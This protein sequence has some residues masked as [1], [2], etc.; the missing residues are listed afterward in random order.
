MGELLDIRKWLTK[1]ETH[2]NVYWKKK[3]IN[4]FMNNCKNVK[5]I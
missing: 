4:E 5:N 2:K 3:R 1:L